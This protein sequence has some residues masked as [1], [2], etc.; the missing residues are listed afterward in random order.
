MNNNEQIKNV[1]EMYEKKK[2]AE[3]YLHK[4]EHN[5]IKER[6]TL[7]QGVFG[8]FYDKVNYQIIGSNHETLKELEEV[9]ENSTKRNSTFSTDTFYINLSEVIKFTKEFLL[10]ADDS[11]YLGISL[12]FNG[13]DRYSF[14]LEISASENEKFGSIL[15][16]NGIR[17]EHNRKA[18]KL[19]QYTTTV[20][21]YSE[22]YGDETANIELNDYDVIIHI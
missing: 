3:Q 12:F 21:T 6:A 17:L 9:L 22:N 7:T 10:N 5:I 1:L 19:I 14:S 2:S 11:D 13:S 18:T 16:I 15:I 4:I 8:S 20:T